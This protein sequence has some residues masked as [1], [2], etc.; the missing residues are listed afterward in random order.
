[1][2]HPLWEISAV[3]LF[4]LLGAVFAQVPFPLEQYQQYLQQKQQQTTATGTERYKTPPIYSVDTTSLE[5][6]VP[7]YPTEITPPQDTLPYFDE[8][9]V[10]DGETVQVIR[11]A[12]PTMLKIYGADIFNNTP[13]ILTAQ[14]PVSDDYVLGNGDLLMLNIWGGVNAQYQLTIDRE[15]NIYIPQVGEVSVAG[16]SLSKAEKKVKRVLASSYSN[17]KANLS[18]ASPK[19]IRVFVVGQVK[20]PGVY[21]IP[22]LSRA[23]TALAAAGG[24][25][26]TGSFRNISIYRNGKAVGKLDIYKFIQQGH[27]SGNIQLANGDVVSVPAYSV[28]AK[29]RGRVKNPAIYELITGETLSDLLEYAGEPL[30]DANINSIFIDRIVDGKHTA[31]SADMKDSMQALTKIKDGDDISLFSSNPYRKDVVFLEGYVPQPGAYG[32]FNGMKVSDLFKDKENLFDDTYLKRATLLRKT[33]DGERKIISFVLGDA[34]AQKPGA[35]LKLEPQDK[36]VI[37]SKRIFRVKKFV[38]IRGAVR[39]PGRYEL[40]EG[41]RISDLVFL[42]GGLSE[43]AFTDSAEFVRIIDGQNVHRYNIN[44]ENVLQNPGGPD[45]RVLSEEDYVLIRS[46]P[47]WRKTETIVV[48]GE[49]NF[50]GT[51]ALTSEDEKLSE[52]LKRVGGITEKGFL[53]GALFVRPGIAEQLSKRNII[54]VVRGTQELTRDSLGQIDTTL[55]IF[56]WNPIDLNRVI[57]DMRE[58][59]AGKDD[60]TLEPGDTIFIP[61]R[62]D[63]VSVVGAIASNGTVK[64]LKGKKIRYYIDRAGGLTKNADNNEIRLVKPN[65][66]VLKVSMGYRKLSPGD[67]IV[68]PQQVKKEGRWLP[69]IKDVVSILSGVATTIYILIKL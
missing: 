41:M 50:P 35:D 1:M 21:D 24:P 8:P 34:I 40:Y 12:V 36:I 39:S 31:I 7:Q 42:A 69:T 44:L 4:I 13:Q 51:Y 48:L 37:V 61:R 25:D 56:N 58:I 17:F 5:K 16:L 10:V 63:G 46:I 26:S 45:D 30:P 15:G 2:R 9:V 23:M 57:I 28:H 38:Y 33:P 52:L 14:Q 47:N 18:V 60:M 6:G 68:V 3:F 64:Y 19:S 11:K 49:V 29:L 66:K 67:V 22:G 59:V 62:P 55:L 32:W 53:E 65:G 43:Y 27:D 20:L 54:R